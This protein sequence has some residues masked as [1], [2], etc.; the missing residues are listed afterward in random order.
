MQPGCNCRIAAKAIGPPERGDHRILKRVGG[1]FRVAQR[2]YGDR[3]QPVPMAPEQHAKRIGVAR[4]VHPE[5]FSVGRVLLR[6]GASGWLALP[7][8]EVALGLAIVRIRRFL[9]SAGS[10]RSVC[11]AVTR[12]ELAMRPC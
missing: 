8:Q 9:P 3:P 4:H 11:R 12:A 10:A 1:F 2:A 6:A 7:G 5:Q